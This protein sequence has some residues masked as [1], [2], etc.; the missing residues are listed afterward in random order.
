MCESQNPRR[1]WKNG[2]PDN[3]GI[4]AVVPLL[5][6]PHHREHIVFDSATPVRCLLLLLPLPHRPTAYA[7]EEGQLLPLKHPSGNTEAL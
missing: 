3:S 1:H 2:T 5:I 6:C 7:L 4:I